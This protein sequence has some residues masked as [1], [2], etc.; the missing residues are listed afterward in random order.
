MRPTDAKLRRDVL[1]TLQGWKDRAEAEAA[2][3]EVCPECRGTGKIE[4]G[5]MIGPM[6]CPTCKGTGKA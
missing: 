2:A 1:S 3:E 6:K 5:T 4:G